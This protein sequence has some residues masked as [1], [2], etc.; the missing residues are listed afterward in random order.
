[1]PENVGNESNEGKKQEEGLLEK[2]WE[3]NEK[4]S[5]ARALPLAALVD[6]GAGQGEE[7][8]DPE[9]LSRRGFLGLSLGA[10]P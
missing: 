10:L 3:D 1:M 2:L 9:G 7:E 6:L 4:E 8:T 5:E